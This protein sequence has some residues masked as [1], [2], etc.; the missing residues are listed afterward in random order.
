MIPRGALRLGFEPAYTNWDR[1]FNTDGDD[2]PLGSL[3]STDSLGSSQLATLLPAEAAVRAITGDGSFRFRLGALRGRLDADI[4]RLPFTLGLGITR[5]LSFVATVPLVTT[6]MNSTVVLDTAGTNAGWNQASSGADN[7]AAADSI[8]TL[9]GELAGAAAQL[10]AAIAGGSFGCPA[11]AQCDQ[12]RDLVTR[13]RDLAANLVML[14]GPAAG[15]DQ[16]APAPPFAPLASSPA[17]VAVRD[18]VAA[19]GTELQAFGI[20]PFTGSFPRPT[21]PPDADAVDRVLVGADYGYGATS[22]LTPPRTVKVSGV[23][24]IELGLRVG[25]A[26][27]EAVRAVLG[28]IVRLPTGKRDDPANFLDLGN[29]DRQTDLIGTFDAALEPGRLGLWLSAAYTM[30]LADRL[31]LRVSPPTQPF[32]PATSLAFVERNLGDI[33]R[34]GA[35]PSFRLAP[36]FRVF[37]S[38]IYERKWTDKVTRDGAPVPELEAFTDR[39]TLAFGAGLLYRVDQGRTGQTLPIEAS[40]NYH[41]AYFGKGGLAPKTG[42]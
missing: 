17:G 26:Q 36:D 8:M 38:A 24:D 16:A 42:R 33:L 15:G 37:L 21:T 27:G 29:G 14:A 39:E 25:L 18:A 4:R 11:S 13:T 19:L 32:P 2:V 5:W 7:A 22:P 1:L 31:D 41:A 10:E 35:H 40:L 6:R 28:A 20:A 3:L 9:V 34:V 30:Q 23:G 12:A